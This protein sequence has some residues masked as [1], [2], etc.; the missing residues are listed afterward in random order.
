MINPGLLKV[1]WCP[2]TR[3]RLQMAETALIVRLNQ[4]IA[5]G[6]LK[7]RGGQAVSMPLDGGLVRADGRVLFPV[8]RDIPVLLASEAIELPPA[9]RS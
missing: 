2:E 7:N 3:Q 6:T 9:E 8:R 4:Q 1:I 5:A